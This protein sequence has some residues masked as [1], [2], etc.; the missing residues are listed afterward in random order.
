MKVILFLSAFIITGLPLVAQ[1]K[2][3][4]LIH[5]VD[6]LLGTAKSKTPS[7]L[8]HSAGTELKG[9]TFPATGRPWGMTNWTPETRLTENKCIAPYYYEDEYVYGFRGSHWTS[10]SCMQ[11]YG[12]ITI[13]PVM[14]DPILDPEK[15]KLRYNHQDEYSNPAYYRLDIKEQVMVE[16][17]G[18]ERTGL[19]KFTCRQSGKFTLMIKPNSDE[20]QGEVAFLSKTHKLMVT[21]PVHRIY[22]GIG[23][24]AGFSGYSQVSFN[25]E[26]FAK[27][28]YRDHTILK[29]QTATSGENYDVG[30][31]ISFNVKAGDIIMVKVGTSFT[32][33]EN[34]Q[35]NSQAEIPRW[36]FGQIRKESEK[37]WDNQL[38]K[39][40]VTAPDSLK[41]IF[42]TALYHT[43][44]TPRM[45]SDVNGSYP[46]F[47]ANYKTATSGFT[48]YGDFSLWDTYRAVHPLYAL[49]FPSRATDMARTLISMAEESGWMPNF[50]CW[51]NFTSAM[52]GD[53]AAIVL[54][55]VFSKQLISTAEAER[56]LSYLN[57][58]A[59]R[60]PSENEYKDGRGRRALP[61][62]LKYGYIPLEDS[63]WDAFHKREQVSRTLEYSYDDY[64]LSVIA[65]NLKNEEME[66]YY[67]AR[68]NNY[69][70][71]VD[72][73]SRFARGRYA[74]GSWITPFDPTIKTFFITEG[75]P[76]QYTFNVPHAVNGLMEKLGGE[77]AFEKSLDSL[78][79]SG[80]YWH[81]NEPGH[82]IPYLYNYCHAAFKTQ[83]VIHQIRMEE[84]SSGP[85]GLSGND[86]SGQMSAWFIFSS[87][88]FYPLIPAEPVY[89][90]GVP[91]FEKV[92]LNLQH[93]K[94]FIIQAINLSTDNW[95]IKTKTLNGSILPGTKLTYNEL[96][97]GGNLTFYM[98]N[99]PAR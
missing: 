60:S 9:Q 88:G 46:V 5:F 71:V 31:F 72:G 25:K 52:V 81:G 24:P 26:P 35:Q 36:D 32:S 28:V 6:P 91:L 1:N 64:A 7:A 49:L 55:D 41:T 13:T 27:G 15:R 99:K 61:S 58:N 20:G 12:S 97:K 33:L 16:I 23:Q 40:K 65:R 78:F 67:A 2:D 86:D 8:K 57:K 3:N 51:N 77:N 48:R 14:G 94:K 29:G 38:M 45:Y 56:A 76:W 50:P 93:E 54:A 30:A 19:L 62:Y 66:H 69:L 42:Y 39:I 75:S 63:V 89:E 4:S 21:N 37:E 90:I 68:S 87:L 82:H 43:M 10:G 95:Y 22:Q 80:H 17:T 11:D 96:I 44:L 92:E 98:A 18:T 83:K 70:N 59:T 47:A 34:A 73:T 53:H 85:G 74:N 79:S 84:Y